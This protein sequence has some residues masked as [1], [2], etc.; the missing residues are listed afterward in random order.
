MAKSLTEIFDEMDTDPRT[1]QSVAH[2]P[3]SSQP[4]IE[5]GKI[6]QEGIQR[7]VAEGE[8]GNPTDAYNFMMG[9]NA[10]LTF[11]SKATGNRFTYRVRLSDDK[12]MFFVSLLVGQSNE[13]D[14][15]YLGHV[16]ADT[17]LYFHGRKSR[18]NS[19]APGAVAFTWVYKQLLRQ[20]LPDSLEIWHEGVCGRCG[21]KLTVPE[22]VKSGFGPECAGKVQRFF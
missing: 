11:R 16:F 14:Y 15:Q 20:T 13:T 12:R 6:E 4:T 5:Q 1:G 9:G 19:S 2:G 7:F 17:Q 10:T 21:R 18:I 22:S 8:L 3:A